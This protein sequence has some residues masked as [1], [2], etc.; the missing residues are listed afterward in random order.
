MLKH[1]NGLLLVLSVCFKRSE[2]GELML[3]K[4]TC[5]G[6]DLWAKNFDFV[7]VACPIPLFVKVVVTLLTQLFFQIHSFDFLGLAR[8]YRF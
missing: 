3:E 2:S 1:P 6:I 5:N 4:Q 7:V 8:R